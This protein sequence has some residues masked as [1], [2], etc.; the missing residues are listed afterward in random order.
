MQ[1]TVAIDDHGGTSPG[2]TAGD[3]ASRVHI[4]EPQV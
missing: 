2:G 3:W 4:D 1:G